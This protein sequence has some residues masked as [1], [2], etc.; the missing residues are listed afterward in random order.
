MVLTCFDPAAFPHEILHLD[1]YV[2]GSVTR[3]E[4]D[5]FKAKKIFQDVLTT[6]NDTCMEYF[7]RA[8]KDSLVD[9]RLCTGLLFLLVLNPACSQDFV[10]RASKDATLKAKDWG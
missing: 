4:H 6:T 2:P 3:K 5:R 10:R 1:F 7:L 9:K 8:M